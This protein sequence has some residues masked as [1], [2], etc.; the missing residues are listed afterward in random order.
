[1]RLK[2][3]WKLNGG[4]ELIDVG[5]GFFMVKFDLANDRAKIIN[6]GPWMHFDHYLTVHNWSPEFVSSIEKINK[7]MV[8]VRIPSL[9]LVFYD[10]SFLMAMGLAIGKLIKVD[11]HTLH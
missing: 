9:N 11:L 7:A 10:E 3:V 5:N 8:W 1:M 2:G 4:F 6:A